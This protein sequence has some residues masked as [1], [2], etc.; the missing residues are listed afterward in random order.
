MSMVTLV[1]G[2]CRSGKSSHALALAEAIPN[3]K[4]LFLATSVPTDGEMEKRVEK[5]R[6]E[7]GRE[8]TT[9]EVPVDLP[10]C[11]LSHQGLHPPTVMVVDCLT[12]WVSNLMFHGF[13]EKGI[14]NM[15][16]RLRDALNNSSSPIFLVSNEVGTGVVPENKLARQFRDFAGYVNQ[17]VA[18]KAHRVIYMVAGIP[19]VIK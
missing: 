15:T 8:W 1:L 17:R 13:D 14:S 6:N 11:I 3:G 12:L 19:W 2:G 10:G 7:R 16:D 18:A 9:I 4:K 5:H